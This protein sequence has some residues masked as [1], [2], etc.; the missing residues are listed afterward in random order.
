MRERKIYIV[1]RG[2]PRGGAFA[3]KAQREVCEAY[4][5]S[6][7]L[8][9]RLVQSFALEDGS[10]LLPT[11]SV[12]S[13]RLKAGDI[14]ICPSLETI[15]DDVAQR[16]AGIRALLGRGVAVHILS[17]FGG[18]I[19]AYASMLEDAY[20]IALERDREIARIKEQHERE[21]AEL[22][23]SNAAFEREILSTIIARYG[24]PPSG[25]E[26]L[27]GIHAEAE[28]KL[29]HVAAQA[30][31]AAKPEEERQRVQDQ[32]IGAWLRSLRKAKG[33]SLEKLSDLL[34]VSVPTLSRA[35]TSGRSP[36]IGSMV[37][38][39]SPGTSQ[40]ADGIRAA[41]AEFFASAQDTHVTQPATQGVAAEAIGA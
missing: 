33:W 27:T 28:S 38:L 7:G 10:A 9:P 41:A 3:I 8:H 25:L 16:I 15:S 26:G 13:D 24:L 21:V 6:R 20:A 17:P 35:E 1:V 39:L 36:Q 29:A 12:I 19:G 34:G 18:D 40:D 4:A 5:M 22:E 11:H 37:A 23:L 31:E 14:L 32:E 2:N 30:R